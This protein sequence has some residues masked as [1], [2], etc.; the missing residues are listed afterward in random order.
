[1]NHHTRALLAGWALAGVT[2]FAWQGLEHT[3][4]DE[5]AGAGPAGFVLG[6]MRQPQPGRWVIRPEGSGGMLVHEPDAS[7]GYAL[8]IAEAAVPPDL[9]AAVRIRLAGGARAGGLVWRYR[10]DQ[11]YY[12][13]ML[14]VAQGTLSVYRVAAGNRIRLEFEDDLELDPSAWHT[15][16]VVHSGSRIRASLGG[17]RVFDDEDRRNRWNDRESHVGLLATGN[18]EAHFDDL[19]VSATSEKGR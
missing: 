10:D 11:H 17:I 7:T 18:S 12:S 6:A 15:L 8:A 13:L 9:T 1:M 14:D 2:T 16:K 4:D 3:F 19:R 5:R